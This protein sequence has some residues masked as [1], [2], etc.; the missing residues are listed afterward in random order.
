MEEKMYLIIK[1]DDFGSAGVNYSVAS[2]DKDRASAIGKLLALETLNENK[3]QVSYA[4]WS[5]DHGNLDI[6]AEPKQNGA[7]QEAGQVY[8]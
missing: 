5:S 8:E 4:I 1:K 3:K 2:H 7:E 6:D